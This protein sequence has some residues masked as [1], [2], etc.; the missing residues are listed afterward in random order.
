MTG[1]RS[2][3]LEVAGGGWRWLEVAG[4]SWR[5]M[6]GSIKVGGLAVARSACIFRTVAAAGVLWG[7]GGGVGGGGGETAKLQV[8]SHEKLDQIVI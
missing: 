6:V 5:C 7:G 2:R 1:D 4:G 3:W 8:K